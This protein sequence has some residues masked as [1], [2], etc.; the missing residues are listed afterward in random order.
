MRHAM[1]IITLPDDVLYNA[2]V[3]G[4]GS[5]EISDAILVMRM[6]MGM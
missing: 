3:D 1:Q 4:N 6:A 2:D 5:I